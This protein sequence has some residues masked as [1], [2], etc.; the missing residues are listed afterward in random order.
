[1]TNTV[2]MDD[3]V[4]LY[5]KAA[6]ERNE[7]KRIPTAKTPSGPLARMMEIQVSRAVTPARQQ[8]LPDVSGGPNALPIP[9]NA[10]LPFYCGT[11]PVRGDKVIVRVLTMDRGRI[12]VPIRN[13]VREERID[14]FAVRPSSVEWKSVQQIPPCCC[15]VAVCQRVILSRR[16]KLLS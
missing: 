7:H 5:G 1:M 8:A 13:F 10:R 12:Q 9:K 4:A 6:K 16:T 2:G 11:N 15:T 14:F 3:L